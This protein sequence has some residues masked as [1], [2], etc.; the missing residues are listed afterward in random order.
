MTKQRRRQHL[1]LLTAAAVV[2]ALSAQ[3]QAQMPVIDTNAITQLV[4]Q[5]RTA[6]QQYQQLVANY[7]QLVATYQSLAQLTNINSVANELKQPWMQNP[8]PSTTLVPGLLN[9]LSPPSTLGGNLATL[10]QQ[11]L[12]QN[13]VYEPQGTDF[14]AQ[15]LRTAANAVAQ[16][17]AVAT[18][19][20]QA[21]EARASA[22]TQIQSQLDSAGTI[23]KVASIQARLVAELN[24]V[25]IQTA[26]AENLRTLAAARTDTQDQAQEQAER[27]SDD[28]TIKSDCAALA[29]LGSNS[30]ECQ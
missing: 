14:Q 10:A 7:N 27:Q 11:Y 5:L 1:R 29:Q 30:S 23:Q 19:N 13:R 12:G 15:Q 6:Q 18:Q 21:L 17:E 9:G 4:S 25:A 3:A 8:A 24:Y 20:L 2:F 22:L 28:E 26:Q 16:I